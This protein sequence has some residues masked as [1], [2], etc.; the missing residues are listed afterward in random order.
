MTEEIDLKNVRENLD[1]LIEAVQHQGTSVVIHNADQP[2]A[3]LLSEE[4]YTAL[5]KLEKEAA[6]QDLG[7]LLDAVHGRNAQFDE[8][9]ARLDVIQACRTESK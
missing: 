1:A 2:V 7:A 9:D 8:D 6:L 5:K 3:V 4:E